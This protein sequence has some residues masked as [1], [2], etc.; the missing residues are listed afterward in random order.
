MAAALAASSR[1]RSLLGR[2]FRA[3]SLWGAARVAADLRSAVAEREAMLT[4][5]AGEQGLGAAARARPHAAEAADLRRELSARE[6]VAGC[7]LE[8]Q[9]SEMERRRDDDSRVHSPAIGQSPVTGD[10]RED[11]TEAA[12]RRDPPAAV[13][14]PPDSTPALR[15]L[16]PDDTP[17]TPDDALAAVRARSARG[18]GAA[19]ALP[20]DAAPSAAEH[21][22]EHERLSVHGV[23]ARALCGPS[24]GAMCLHCARTAD[25]G[26]AADWGIT[27]QVRPIVSTV[28]GT[29]NLAPEEDCSDQPL[30]LCITLKDFQGTPCNG[31]EVRQTEDGRPYFIDHATQKTTE[32]FL[33]EGERNFIREGQPDPSVRPP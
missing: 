22:E 16:T 9:L 13:A 7:V 25:A 33:R 8:R 30:G 4:D 31:W 17:V 19:A 2:S 5:A 11:S 3:L 14:L 1:R 18:A 12:G 15:A 29:M 28:E 6:G 23:D 32:I 24:V 10:E 20:W 26:T 27:N 21:E